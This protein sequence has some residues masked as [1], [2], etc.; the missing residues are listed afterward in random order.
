[1]FSTIFQQTQDHNNSTGYL[2]LKVKNV[3]LTSPCSPSALCWC[4]RWQHRSSPSH[5]DPAS[6]SK[7]DLKVISKHVSH[8]GWDRSTVRSSLYY[9]NLQ[10]TWLSA[11]LSSLERNKAESLSDILKYCVWGVG[12]LPCWQQRTLTRVCSTGFSYQSG[13][14][15]ILI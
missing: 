15:L 2:A 4:R 7:R 6:D 1:M 3:V 10:T 14:A 5:R 13:K 12:G 9:I 11:H 8:W